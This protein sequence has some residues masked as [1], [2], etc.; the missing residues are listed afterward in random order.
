MPAWKVPPIWQD[1]RCWI[2]GGGSSLTKVFGIPDDVVKK[3]ASGEYP[4]HIYSDFLSVLHAE[5][6]IGINNAYQIGDWIDAMFFGDSTWYLVHRLRLAKFPG[7]KLTCCPR[8]DKRKKGDTDGIKYVPKDPGKRHGIHT[9]RHH[10]AWNSNSGAASI[11]IANH[12]GVKQILLLG[13]DM[14]I[15]KKTSY[16]HWHGSHSRD[17]QNRRKKPAFGRHLKGFPEIAEDARRIGIE[18]LNVSPTSSI[19]VFPKVK[20]S[21]VL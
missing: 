19:D 17:I 12:F 4:S 14:N 15:D 8:F 18:I 1:G 20:L 5:H 10:V 7:L 6:V 3:V 2:I 11:S 21:D 16:S 9:D 13:F